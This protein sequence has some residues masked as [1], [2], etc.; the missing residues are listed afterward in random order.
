MLESCVDGDCNFF[1]DLAAS[2]L[3]LGIWYQ[4]WVWFTPTSGGLTSA[5]REIFADIFADISQR[6]PARYFK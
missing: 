5:V 1:K 2:S 3:V 4:P 6:I